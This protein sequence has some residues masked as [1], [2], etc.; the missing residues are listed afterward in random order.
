MC[1]Y[2]YVNKQMYIYMCHDIQTCLCEYMHLLIYV[3]LCMQGQPWCVYGS[4]C[5][6]KCAC[7]RA[8]VCMRVCAPVCPSVMEVFHDGLVLGPHMAI[9]WF[10]RKHRL[11]CSYA[12][13]QFYARLVKSLNTRLYDGWF[14]KRFAAGLTTVVA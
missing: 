14:C 11:V 8:Y 2:G 13:S 10:Q 4:S 9:A 1:I 7:V 6:C 12:T 5:F 3:N